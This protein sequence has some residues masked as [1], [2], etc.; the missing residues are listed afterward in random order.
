MATRINQLAQASG[1]GL[2]EDVAYGRLNG[3]FLN[4]SIN[5]YTG[6]TS[7]IAFLRRDKGVDTTEIESFFAKKK[8][9]HA[10]N[11]L[12]YDGQAISITIPR[13][14]IETFQRLL[15]SLLFSFTAADTVQRAPCAK[16]RTASEL[17]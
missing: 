7:I 8:Y 13:P 5:N 16:R 6:M 11:R 1:L 9:I 10:D 15:M 17:L 14:A 12:S 3:I 2:Y 4:V